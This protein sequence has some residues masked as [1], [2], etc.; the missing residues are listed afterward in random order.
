MPAATATDV[1]YVR[2][3][4]PD[5]ER[6]ADFLSDFG[7]IRLEEPSGEPDILRFRGYGTAPFLCELRKGK[8]G[9]DG[10]GLTLG[11]E[12]D[13]HAL[14][15]RSGRPI[16]RV[17][18]PGGGW[19]VRLTDPDGIGVDAVFGQAE[20]APLEWPGT[21]PWNAVEGTGRPGSPKRLQGGPAHV[22]RLGHVVMLVE[23]VART[24]SWLIDWFGF[25]VSDL[26]KTNDD[27]PVAAFI[28]CDRGD[29]L[30]DHHSVNIAAVPDGRT[31]FHHAAFEVLDL[32]DLLLG[33][34]HLLSN[35]RESVWGVGRHLLG[36]QVFDYWRDPGGIIF[37]HWTDG[38]VLTAS[39][40]MHVGTLAD[41]TGVQWGPPMAPGFV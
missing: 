17:E 37:E 19:R 32:D 38:D 6:S 15:G 3:S 23:D 22:V 2:Y 31:G 27:T 18:G 30:T 16:E 35:G 21:V 5:L 10:Y 1:A 26:I 39:E 4:V 13:L 36:S 24:L 41:M 14:A 11:T 8:P 12:A 40:P 29:T 20:V 25:L 34:D 28:R 9:F 33:R 7:L